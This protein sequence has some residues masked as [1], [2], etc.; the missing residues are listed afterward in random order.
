MN[1]NM[2]PTSNQERWSRFELCGMA[3]TAA[4][5][6]FLLVPILNAGTRPADRS[7][8]IREAGSTARI[9]PMVR[10]AEHDVGAEVLAR[11]GKAPARKL[12]CGHQEMTRLTTAS[13]VQ[14]HCVAGHRWLS[15]RRGWKKQD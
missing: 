2:R 9:T 12:P 7:P 3:V 13:G 4:L 1:P 6:G 11:H 15:R 10:V 14:A 5:V 8:H